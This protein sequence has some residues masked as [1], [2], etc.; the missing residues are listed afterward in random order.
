M[1]TFATNGTTIVAGGENISTKYGW[2]MKSTDGGVT[3]TEFNTS[4]AFQR[5][6]KIIW[7]GTVFYAVGY[8]ASSDY[9]LIMYST[10]GTSWTRATGGYASG[11]S[12]AEMREIDY[13]SGVGYCAV[14]GGFDIYY[15]SDGS[16]WSKSGYSPG[17]LI[18]RVIAIGSLF[19]ANA[20]NG[21]TSYITST[22]GQFWTNR[23]IPTGMGAYL[24]Q[25]NFANGKYFMGGEIAPATS[26]NGTT[27]TVVSPFNGVTTGAL[28]YA[29]SIWLSLTASDNWLYGSQNGNYFY[30]QGAPDIGTQA[31]SGGVSGVGVAGTKFLLASYNSNIFST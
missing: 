12:S 18:T 19:V 7:T 27:W 31:A 28:V 4:I 1:K 10:D 3:W 8:M 14:G 13:I 21:S 30:N 25:F 15:S 26:T 24:S 20:G 23:T 11:S 9:C 22:T 17:L 5:V 29:N 6:N 2:L 16:T